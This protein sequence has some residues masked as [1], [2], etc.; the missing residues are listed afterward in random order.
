MRFGIQ[1]IGKTLLLP[2]GA[3]TIPKESLMLKGKKG[4]HPWMILMTTTSMSSKMKS[5]I[6][7]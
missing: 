1:W 7:W 6:E 3:W 5:I 4:V 2:L